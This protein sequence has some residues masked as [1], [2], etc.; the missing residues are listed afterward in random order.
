MT[1][2][3]HLPIKEIFYLTTTLANTRRWAANA[4]GRFG[5]GLPVTS[6]RCIICDPWT[7]A[8]LENI[9]SCAGGSK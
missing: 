5:A 3:T 7:L 8:A 9:P 6:S 1:Y 2:A 4:I